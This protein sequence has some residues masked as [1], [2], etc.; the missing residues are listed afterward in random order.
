MTDSRI[1]RL[2][3]TPDRSEVLAHATALVQAAWSEFDQ[4]R[5][6]E[7]TLSAEL[8]ELF[9]SPLPEEPISAITALDEASAALDASIAQSRPRYLAYIGSSGLEIG[10]LADLLAHSYDTNLALDAGGASRI[11]EQAVAW[12][13]Q[14]VGYPA[15]M[16][17]FTS[18]GTVSNITALA[19]AR[20]FAAPGSRTHGVTP[21]SLALYVSDEAHYSVTRAA[22]LLGIGTTSVR[23]IPIDGNRRM[24]PRA[25]E[26]AI[27][28]DKA[29]GVTPMAVVATAGT[30]LTGAVDPIDA[31]ADICEREGVWLHV[32]GAYGLPA[33]ATKEAGHEF[34]GLARADSVSVDAHKWLFVPKACSV[35]MVKDPRTLAATFSH[36]EAY[37]PHDQ[38]APNP[39]D[40]TLE[41]SRPLRALKLWLA[42][43]VFGADQLR[44]AINANRDQA[45][46]LY[47]LAQANPSLEVLPIEPALSITPVRQVLPECPDVNA[48]NR[49][50]CQAIVDDARVYLS[51][52]VIDGNVWLRPCFTNLRTTDADVEVTAQVIDEV[53]RRIC[54]VH[55]VTIRT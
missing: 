34:T 12:L 25:L 22:E 15:G 39:V 17:T 50:L 1:R 35:L 4:A 41:Y 10:A 54:P 27:R 46:L 53:G 52:A 16:G 51:P 30:T 44:R 18:G 38:S 33:A 9:R 20:E 37:I 8:V 45:H 3:L 29:N 49:A 43:R 47:R 23:R 7:P 32:D 55:E 48:H 26:E 21:G 11:E 2:T 40:V 42:F 13:A 31:L 14:F 5:D 36:D 6:R 19:A 28:N 24:D